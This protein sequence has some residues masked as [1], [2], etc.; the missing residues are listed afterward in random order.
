MDLLDAPCSVRV[1]MRDD[2]VAPREAG[3]REEAPQLREAQGRVVV[4]DADTG[5]TPEGAVCDAAAQ[6]IAQIGERAGQGRDRPGGA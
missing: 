1:R 6:A 3:F 2:P 4:Q 5:Q